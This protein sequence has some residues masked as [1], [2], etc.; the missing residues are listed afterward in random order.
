M[1]VTSAAH[2]TAAPPERESLSDWLDRQAGRLFILPAV[3]LILGF[4]IFPLIA[5]A[6]LALSRFK[7][8][9]GGYTLTFI[10]WFNFKKMLTGSQQFHLLGTFGAITL[11]GW[12]IMLAT[13][14][15]VVWGVVRYVR[16][17][18]VTVVGSIGRL[19]T[20]ATALALS[21]LFA[22]NLGEGGQ[23]GT[24]ATTMFYVAGGVAVQFA[25]GLG[26]ALLCAKPIRGRSFFRVL[27]FVPLMV[28]PVGIAYT[29]RMLADTAVGPFAPLW[30]W[31]GYAQ[32]S[33][34][35]DAWTARFVVLI[36]DSWQWI[37]FIFIVLLAAIESQPRDEVEA[38]QLDGASGWQIFR[39]ITWPSIAPVAATVVLIRAI[40]AFKII[41]LP[42]VLTNGGPGIA[43]E[44][45]TLHAFIEW[46][47]LN[48]GGSAAVAYILLFL[49][50]IACVSFFNF[51]VKP[52]REAR[53]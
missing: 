50:T 10:G 24:I 31:L 2:V 27:F 9:P 42:N 33:W 48:L 1:A 3:I 35:A 16:S 26:L 46:R 23:L 17:G 39:D 53:A 15:L 21:V 11:L 14:A 30:H 37:P 51:V 44:S 36:G 12:V 34:S 7:L 22:V 8:A 25:L 49:S 19:I 43:T 40:E 18:R 20:I 13:V 38:A 32:T 28:T 29:F 5:S 4:S 52:M 47:A 45:L 41:D 6:Y